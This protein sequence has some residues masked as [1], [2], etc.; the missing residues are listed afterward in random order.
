M[1]KKIFLL[2]IGTIVFVLFIVYIFVFF[3]INNSIKSQLLASH[4]V[5]LDSYVVSFD[6]TI[7]QVHNFLLEAAVDSTL[8]FE[9]ESSYLS[10]NAA[11]LA[12][13]FTLPSTTACPIIA[14]LSLLPI[15]SSGNA[16]AVNTLNSAHSESIPEV[17]K[18]E[19]DFYVHHDGERYYLRI[20]QPVTSTDNWQTKLGILV[21]DISLDTLIAELGFSNITK[22][23]TILILN[24]ENEV[25]YPYATPKLITE[26]D[27]EQAVVNGSATTSSYI[28]ASRNLTL[29]GFKLVSGF[30]TNE[31]SKSTSSLN[32]TIAISGLFAAAF[33]VIIALFVSYR[34]TQPINTLIHHMNNA[35]FMEPASKPRRYTKEIG[36]LYDNYNTMVS[37]T[38]VL[39]DDIYELSKNEKEVE[40]K[41][42]QAQIN[43]HFLYNVLDSIN[44]VAI[45]H[46][47]QDISDMVTALATM[48]RNSLNRGKNFLSTK[49][50][51]SIVESYLNIQKYRYN[52]TF[53]VEYEIDETLLNKQTIRFVMQ[54]LVENAILHGIQE[55]ETAGIIKICL[56]KNGSDIALLVKNNGILP[57]I[58]RI[59]RILSG[60][61]TVTKSYGI[62]NINTRLKS[63]Y[64][65]PYGLSYSIENGFCIAK[66]LIPG[67][68]F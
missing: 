67:N 1:F 25:I 7:G 64:G 11:L 54:P 32:I 40:L 2:F 36:L 21:A 65:E 17:S 49:Q 48:L 24:G 5:A 15:N 55:S 27:I 42:L 12:S 45:K 53:T 19:P 62:L 8:Q 52:N 20:T 68:N 28:M 29:P 23:G 43:P 37:R 44:W 50:E 4:E 18:T 33:A 57:N 51:L 39:I 34:T 47:V 14:K 59:K 31:I 16:L 26:S 63:T 30:N 66:V 10:E 35:N 46:N 61:D 60:Q 56:Q 38:D 3:Y 41:M 58:D 6:S 9:L 13:N 22:V